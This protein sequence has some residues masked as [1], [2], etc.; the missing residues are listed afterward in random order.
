MSAAP[1]RVGVL[2]TG[3]IGRLHAELLHRRVE[4][5]RVATVFDAHAPSAT[6]VAHDLGVPVA[7][8]AEDLIASEEVDAVAICTSTDTHVPLILAAAAAGKAIFCE[9]PVSLD[10]DAVD[11]ALDAVATASLTFQIGFNRRFDP[12][13][14][15]VRTAVADGTVGAPHLVRITSRDPEPPPAEYVRT[16]GGIFL[17]MTI[18]DFDMARFVTGSEVVAVSA[19]GA[20]RI[21]EDFADAGDVDTAIVTLEHADGCLTAIDNSR[22]ASYG[23][24]QRV[25]VHGECGMAASENPRAHT[26]VVSSA[27]GSATATLPYFFLDRYIPAYVA[28]W[29][30]F[31]AACR[32]G[33]PGTPGVADA[34]APLVIGLAA[35]RSRVEGRRVE[36]AEIE[37]EVVAR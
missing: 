4:G 7:A 25:E 11:A 3:R 6:A 19:H 15:A 36:I 8:S 33:E 17:D 13:H 34:R 21:R 23:Y 18:H 10:L 26:T 5:A 24:D 22:Q 16:S 1:L 20:V 35:L 29:D 28:Q 30:A 2:G 27:A 12:S 31:V 9:K 32:A 14:A 37:A